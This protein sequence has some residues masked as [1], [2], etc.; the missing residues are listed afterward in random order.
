MRSEGQNFVMGIRVEALQVVGCSAGLS[1]AVD[2]SCRR[3]FGGVE[4]GVCSQALSES[5]PEA[6][7]RHQNFAA[8][9]RK[10]R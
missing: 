8:P 2:C 1:S 4:S 6:L 9:Q 5:L 7:L 3:T 10:S